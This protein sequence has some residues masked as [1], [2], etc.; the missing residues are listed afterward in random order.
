MSP[1]IFCLSTTV[2]LI[3]GL[4]VLLFNISLA[5]L[6]TIPGAFILNLGLFFFLLRWIVRILVFPGSI[7]FWKR[8][9]EATY[10]IEMAKQWM[11]QLEQLHAFLQMATNRPASSNAGMTLEGVQT[12]CHVVE[13]LARNLR[14]QQRDQVKFTPEQ[15]HMRLLVTAVESWIQ[16]AKVCDRR[17]GKVETQVNFM[18]WMQRMSQSVV[19]VPL[20]YAIATAP[21]VKE[22]EAEVPACIERL[23]QLMG[24]FD[25]LHRQ[26]DSLCASAFRFL[27]VP[28][29][30]SL[31]Q[32]RAELLV[33]Y[34]GQ[35][36]WVRT[37]SG[38]KIDAMFIS[39]HGAGDLEAEDAMKEDALSTGSNTKEDV[40][41]K[42][43]TSEVPRAGGP[44]IVWCN[45][46]AGYYET[47]A[48]ESHWLDFY[49]SQGCSVLLFNY[50][51]FGRSQGHP[52]PRALA[53]DGNAVIEFLR[54]RGFSQIGV[55]GRSIGG[56]CACS[57]AEA[58]PDVVKIL[59]TDR[60]FSTL[61]KVAKYT[62][63][64]WAVKGLGLSA[65]W[66]DNHRNYEKSRCYKVMICDPND[67]TIPDL[68]ALRSA[69]ALDAVSQ[70]PECNRFSVEDDKI[71]RLAKA[72]AFLDTLINV[73]NRIGPPPEGQ[74]CTSCRG[75]MGDEA[76]GI[77]KPQAEQWEH[78]SVGKELELGAGARGHPHDGDNVEADIRNEGEEDTQRLVPTRPRSQAQDF[79]KH[80]IT[81][82]WIEEHADAVQTVLA[83]HID[84]IRLA[85]DIVGTQLNA[86]GLTLENALSRPS[87]EEACEAF[88]CLLANLQVWGSLSTCREMPLSAHRD[89]ETFF[90][91]GVDQE[92]PLVAARLARLAS[93]LTPEN[94]TVY[95]RQLS[96][97]L[98][99]RVRREFRQQMS[100][101]RRTLEH[102][103]N[104]YG[105]PG[106][107][108]CET[109]LSHFCEIE[110]FVT[111][112][113]RFFKSVDVASLS[114]ECGTDASPSSDSEETKES[115]ERG[116]AAL[117][118]I[119]AITTGFVVCVDCGH[120]GCLSDSELQHLAL[121][122]RAARFGKYRFLTDE[123]EAKDRE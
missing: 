104:N 35:H 70:V 18:D 83:Q 95:H 73:C 5:R 8:N 109:I 99:S 97:A 57:L 117:P 107:A 103:S 84:A 82:T 51:G 92:T 10:R 44:V 38:R 17:N 39:C 56:I 67:A 77:G 122:L 119:N 49:L 55:H 46:N 26:E 85:L 23:E 89:I 121:H 108:L 2:V 12:G 93:N 63:G 68:A 112:I 31:H 61:A 48:Y 6:F 110:S 33:R 66:A 7:L 80:A 65:T 41:L 47:M 90:Q 28:T 4:L 64:N 74:K 24:I 86:S 42:E 94:V 69:V 100:R 29:V 79:R 27:Q 105:S 34:S 123:E 25:G 118:I 13:G 3:I 111:S 36:H 72:W 15:A 98:M 52:T 78:R 45:P 115:M 76:I 14:V 62:F 81:E 88:R 59:I 21:L 116:R 20:S 106:S 16:N 40:P 60:T 9:T 75:S 87:L 37:T 11:H 114:A 54:R 30:G 32:L 19:S 96:R 1:I 91:Q 50:S 22:S 113:C 101:V 53:S 120:N 71:E 58:H 102:A 43:V